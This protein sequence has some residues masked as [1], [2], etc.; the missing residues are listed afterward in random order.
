MGRE[1]ELVERLV[2][3]EKVCMLRE[4]RRRCPVASSKISHVE[5]TLR[6]SG[7]DSTDSVLPWS[8]YCSCVHAGVDK[9]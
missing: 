4:K 1:A 3:K 5:L 9:W 2:T 6:R 8:K 7:E